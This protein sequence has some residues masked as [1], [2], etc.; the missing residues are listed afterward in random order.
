MG[1]LR[2]S[3]PSKPWQRQASQSESMSSFTWLNCGI[4]LN[5]SY[6][7]RESDELP[8][9]VAWHPKGDFFVVPTR[10]HGQSNF[11]CRSSEQVGLTRTS[12]TYQISRSSI[13]IRGHVKATFRLR[14]MM[15]RLGCWPGRRTEC[16]SLRVARTI[17]SL[18]GRR[19][20]RGL[21]RG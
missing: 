8:C 20:A 18:C 19:K 2:A 9:A 13:E 3:R 4:R 16:T 15:A 10:S 12:C 17:R 6:G 14:G 11:R 5:I 1:T 7:Y 21:Y